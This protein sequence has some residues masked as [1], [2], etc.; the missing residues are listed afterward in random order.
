MSELNDKIATEFE[1][2]GKMPVRFKDCRVNEVIDLRTLGKAQAE[3]LIAKGATYIR[4]KASALKAEKE[5]A[6][7]AAKAA[8]GE[9]DNKN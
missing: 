6:K 7:A 3:E 5:A 9:A 4:K 2:V 8:E 1:I